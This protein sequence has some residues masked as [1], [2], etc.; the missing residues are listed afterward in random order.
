MNRLHFQ[1]DIRDAENARVRAVNYE[2]LHELYLSDS[3]RV[4]MDA[5]RTLLGRVSAESEVVDEE[6]SRWKQ[7][8]ADAQALRSAVERLLD[9]MRAE[10][11][12][13]DTDFRVAMIRAL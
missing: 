8:R 3:V 5:V 9:I 11:R 12:R 6:G 2:V 1:L 7:L 13:G 10:M 4:Q